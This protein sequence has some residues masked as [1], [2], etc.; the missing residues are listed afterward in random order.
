MLHFTAVDGDEGGAHFNY[1]IY[2]GVVKPTMFVAWLSCEN[3][4]YL[5]SFHELRKTGLF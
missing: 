3:H 1:L 2:C 4:L 5:K